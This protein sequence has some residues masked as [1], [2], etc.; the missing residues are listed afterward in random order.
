M[1]NIQPTKRSA[2]RWAVGTAIL[3]ILGVIVVLKP[4]PSGE[5][6]D[7]ISPPLESMRAS[8][9]ANLS[10]AEGN[11]SER[12]N[13]AGSK[14]SRAEDSG[15][16]LTNLGAGASDEAVSKQGQYIPVG[17]TWADQ[18]EGM[19]NIQRKQ[20][21][22]G[23]Y[24]AFLSQKYGTDGESSIA[25]VDRKQGK[26]EFVRTKWP[27]NW[28]GVA[29][30]AWNRDGK[31]IVYSEQYND[32]PGSSLEDA[33][34][35][36]H[37]PV[38]KF[39]LTTG[40]A[41]LIAE[42]PSPVKA[43]A[44]RGDETIIVS[45]STTIA[46]MVELRRFR[47]VINI[48]DR[49][50]PTGASALRFQILPDQNELWFA[51]IEIQ[52]DWFSKCRW[53]L[54]FVD[55]AAANPAVFAVLENVLAFSWNEDGTAIAVLR[56]IPGPGVEIQGW[57]LDLFDRGFRRIVNLV[58]L[59]EYAAIPVGFDASGTTVYLKGTKYPVLNRLELEAGGMGIWEYKVEVA[60]N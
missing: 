48:E 42:I 3:A 26:T 34:L 22:D 55:L 35:V 11:I 57:V 53:S 30:F 58:Q 29:E 60:A 13:A 19:D 51:A 52:D 39:D 10:S 41:S 4:R 5:T 32:P 31:S 2:R 9:S 23:R 25:L 15:E 6:G 1:P 59:A 24:D 40:D 47:G 28:G 21:P 43:L 7:R 54:G 8:G 27:K 49:S 18:P 56:L 14:K 46:N 45:S 12:L 37:Y 33:P 36:L 38:Y 50:I 16:D 20:S 44:G 17:S